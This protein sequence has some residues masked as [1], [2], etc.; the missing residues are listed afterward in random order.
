MAGV[1]LLALFMA[2]LLV[3][4]CRS[5]RIL[6]AVGTELLGARQIVAHLDVRMGEMEEM[7]QH[8]VRILTA[9]FTG[10]PPQPEDED[11]E[12]GSEEADAASE[13]LNAPESS[14]PMGAASVLPL[15]P[16]AQSTPRESFASRLRN[17][18]GAVVK[19]LARARSRSGGESELATM[20]GVTVETSRR[21]RPRTAQLT[22]ELIAAAS[23][24]RL[25]QTRPAAPPPPPPPEDASKAD[26]Q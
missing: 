16:L 26:N 23:A 22:A 5:S 14:A 21:R 6:L 8:L 3:L 4:V 10:L 2:V 11:D 12:T 1:V 17:R 15:R 7:S 9:Y 20:L 18:G 24:N 19:R 13:E 25:Q